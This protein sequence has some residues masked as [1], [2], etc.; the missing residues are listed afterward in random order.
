M[1]NPIINPIW[2]Y[3]INILSKLG[4]LCKGVSI[5]LVIVLTLL[6]AIYLIWRVDSFYPNDKDD[7]EFND[8]CKRGFKNAI[9]TTIILIILAVVIPSE[10]IMYAMLASNYITPANLEMTGDTITDMV[11]YV[12]EKVDELD[13]KDE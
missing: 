11:D 5:T 13:N 4:G 1:S 7:V 3:F 8:F 10:K 9:I 2:I 12:F 6:T